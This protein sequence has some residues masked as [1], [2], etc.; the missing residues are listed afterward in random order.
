MLLCSGSAQTSRAET[1]PDLLGPARPRP[2]HVPPL[3]RPIMTVIVAYADITRRKSQILKSSMS[4][5]CCYYHIILH[6]RRANKSRRYDL[7]PP[8]QSRSSVRRR[9]NFDWPLPVVLDVAAPKVIIYRGHLPAII[10]IQ[11]GPAEF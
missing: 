10:I 5:R 3:L 8:P 6:G 2:I 11:Y 1:V 4:Y 7:S 9:R